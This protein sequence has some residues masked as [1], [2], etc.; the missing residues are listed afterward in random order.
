M[1]GM[2]FALWPKNFVVI[3]IHS[4]WPVLP[5]LVGITAIVSACKSTPSRASLRK[6]KTLQD[7]R[8]VPW[9]AFEQLTAAYYREHGYEADHTGQAGPDGGIDLKMRKDG[10]RILVQCKRYNG[11]S[12]GAGRPGILRRCCRR[13]RYTTSKS[14]AGDTTT[15][16][17]FV[18]GW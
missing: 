9:Q 18:S 7:I 4:L 8:E 16:K 13:G 1:A 15:A 3:I 5:V 6:I 14:L 17:H 12:V 2:A 11:R 10:K